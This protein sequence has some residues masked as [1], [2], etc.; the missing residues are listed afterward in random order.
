MALRDHQDIGPI[1]A[2]F[3][4]AQCSP[5]DLRVCK[6]GFTGIILSSVAGHILWYVTALILLYAFMFHF[7]TGFLLLCV[8]N[9]LTLNVYFR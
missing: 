3:V 5:I 2:Y 4:I 6:G 9:Y 8:F 1:L 7:V